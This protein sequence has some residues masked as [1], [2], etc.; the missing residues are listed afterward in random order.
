MFT[1]LTRRGVHLELGGDLGTDSFILALRQFIARRGQLET[2]WSDNA[3][4]F[5]G[6][7]ELKNI[8]KKSNHNKLINTFVNQKIFWKFKYLLCC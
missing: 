6:V 7:N 4:S 5:V 3:I 8:L 1:Y 2:I